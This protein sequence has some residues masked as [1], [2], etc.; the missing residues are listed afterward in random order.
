MR[1]IMFGTGPFAVPTF[2]ALLESQHKVLALFTRPIADSGKR[3]KT[4]ENPTRDVAESADLLVFDPLNVNDESSIQELQRLNADLFVV[5]DYGQILSNACLETAKKGGI[6][7]HGS[8][9]PKYRGAA[10]INWCLYNGDAVTGITIIHMTAKLDGGPCLAKRELP[11]GADETTET[12]EPKLSVLGVEAVMQSIDQ[13]AEW[14]GVSKIGEVQD[15]SLATKAPRLKKSDGLINWNRSAEE[16]VNQIRAFQP[17]PGS[18][19]NWHSANKKQPIRLIVHRAIAIDGM[20]DSDL[21]LEP[22]QVCRCDREELVVQTGSGLLSV[23]QIQPAGKKTM[24]IADFLR[25][26]P[27]AVGDRLS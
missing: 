8:L 11:I 13:L 6:N 12:I 3:R 21:K 20:S 18:F 9:L 10:P 16:I 22:G 19:T 17:W 4:A 7:L 25:G 14:D 24:P 15:Q 26:N 5:C 23:T 1:I 27:P 2:Q